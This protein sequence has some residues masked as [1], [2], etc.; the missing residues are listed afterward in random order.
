MKVSQVVFFGQQEHHGVMTVTSTR[1]HLC[2]RHTH[3]LY[4]DSPPPPP[5]PP[6]TQSHTLSLELRQVC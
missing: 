6:Y 4:K 1:M 5:P 2:V 3:I